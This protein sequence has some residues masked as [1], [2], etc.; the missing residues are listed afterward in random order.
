[1]QDLAHLRRRCADTIRFLSADAVQKA[2]S[3]HP[4]M[5]MGM[6]DAAAVLWTERMRHN[7]AD[8]TWFNRDRFVL[9][10]GHGSMLLYSLLHLTGYDL[11]MDQIRSFRQWG[12]KT[13]GHP[14]YRHTPGVEMTTGPLGQG[15]STAVGMA[16]AERHLAARYNTITHPI[17]NH[18]TYVIASDGDLM[19]GVSHE[20]C[21]IAGH[22][23][24]GK[25]I[26]LYDDNG[27]SIDGPTS[28]SFTENVLKR[29]E[30]YG[31]QTIEADGHN[32]EEVLAAIDKAKADTDRPA[33]IACKT[34]I[35]FGSPNK[36][37][38][39]SA[40][41]SPLGTDELKLAKETLGWPIGPEFYVPDDVFDYMLSVRINGSKLQSE[42]EDLM[43]DYRAE[44]PEQSVELD[45]AIAGILPTNWEEAL[46]NFALGTKMATREASG[47]ALN[48]LKTAI[49]NL[50]GG[51]AD[52]TPSNNT[53][54]KADVSMNHEDFSGRYLHFGVREHGMGAIVNG[55]TLHGGLLA[56]T[57]TFLAFLDYMRPAVRLAALMEIPSLFVFTHDSI[58]LGEDGP[59]HQPV[60]HLASIRA[61]PNVINFRPADA[62]ETVAAWKYAVQSHLPVTF[63]LSR[64]GLPVVSSGEGVACGAYV[65]SDAPEPQVLLL[66]TGSEVQIALDAQKLLLSEGISS[67]VV[68][69]PCWELFEAQDDAYKASVLPPSITA[70]VA[71]EA[72][73]QFGWERYLGANGAFV[74]M[75][76]FG[77][78]APIDDL[79][80]NF[81][82]TASAVALAAK[83]QLG[84]A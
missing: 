81:G 7:P 58:G 4:G 37:G 49:P 38:K 75:K 44:Y 16:I 73:N 65:L 12:S 63:A 13:A 42:W 70:R 66:S 54:A 27:I 56:Y 83:T 52:L 41:G 80:R 1:M 6:A 36:Q 60:E 30:A 45:R 39:S 31:W 21:A 2:N 9:S 25:L 33:I 61:M 3:G 48:A 22:L 76:G 74:G 20:A 71:V 17:I 8:P 26:V 43:A 47:H 46:P 32:P 5:P 51:S 59:T 35:G 82:I 55:I 77:A 11:S 68:S 10:A 50:L 19:E 28:L 84:L 29:Y 62:N 14:E 18:Y 15:I 23:G 79:Y 24:L 69:M 57:G 40:H 34:H 67:R 78:S 72:A 64:Q 53:R